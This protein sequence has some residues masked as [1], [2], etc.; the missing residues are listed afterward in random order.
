MNDII[1]VIFYHYLIIILNEFNK[2]IYI[3]N[4]GHSGLAQGAHGWNLESAQARVDWRAQGGL[5]IVW[6]WWGWN[7]FYWW[8]GDCVEVYRSKSYRWLIGRND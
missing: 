8:V 3:Q 4:Y 2:K 6:S 5:R 1:R 7:Y